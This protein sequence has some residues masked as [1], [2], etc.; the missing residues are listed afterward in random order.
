MKAKQGRVTYGS[1]AFHQDATEAMGGDIIRALIETVTNSDDAYG[2][3]TGKIR[4][5]VDHRRGPWTVVTR[6]RATGMSASRMEEA[7]AHLG[8]RTSGFEDGADVRGNLGRGSK[9]LAA[10]G[11][12]DFE[13]LCEDEYAH[14]SLDPDG[15][16]SLDS[17]RRALPRERDRLGIP[18]GNGTVVTIHATDSIRCP[19][20]QKL[21]EKLSRHYQLRDI[22]SDPI[23]EVILVDKNKEN[24][25]VLRF[26]FPALPVVDSTELSIQDYP[27]A[28]TKLTILRNT[29]RYDDPQSDATRPAGILI[30]GRRAIYENSLFRFESN[31]YAGWFSGRI[32]CPFIDTL[33]AEYDRKLLAHEP[34]DPRNPVPIITRRRDG[35]Q[36]G[37]PFYKA[38]AAAVEKHIG[39]L[40]AHEEKNA[41]EQTSTESTHLRKM[42][43]GLG[44]D[45]SKLI[46]EDLREID[47][48]GLLGSQSGEAL[49]PIKVIPEE[50][51]LY[52]G[53]EKTVS[54]MVLP[55]LCGEQIH[56]QCEP[57]G[58]VELLD[59]SA[60]GLAP[61]KKRPDL[62][63][64]QVHLRPL[65]EDQTLLT[66]TC[67]EH[68]AVALVEV[69]PERETIELPLVPAD[70]FQFERDN[71]RVAWTRKK[72]LRI[73]AP[74]ADV[75]QYGSDV[76]ISSSDPGVVVRTGKI[77]LVLDEELEQYSAQ[78]TIEAR[79]LSAKAK[80]TANLGPLATSC[81][82]VVS[83][84]EE[85]PSLI[86][87]IADEEAGNYRAI[88]SREG[89]QTTIKVMGRHPIMK[90]YR[91]PATEFPGDDSPATQLVVA[92]IVADQVARMILEKKFPSSVAEHIDAARFYVEH[93]KYMS[94]YL[95]RCHKA[96]LGED[97]LAQLVAVHETVVSQLP[98]P[99]PP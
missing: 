21:A 35:L 50:V 43:D 4:I 31:P 17:P 48:D 90:R 78:S 95:Q 54:V 55:G 40:V 22:M 84:E 12:V 18:R 86:I 59:G 45:L 82:V 44:R 92:E 25:D 70:R 42:L 27:E 15:N 1:R 79:A 61:H 63:A 71:Y 80:L 51:V 87:K 26:A 46:D 72:Q 30:K 20:H 7:I 88:V 41:Q 36:H 53:E 69:R 67:G 24:S 81:R 56:V 13:S 60:V 2:P 39:P 49:P 91:G 47:E 11:K 99:N 19:Q 33:A 8:A 38:L 32:E 29:E 52:M 93:Y 9:D 73:L 83:K 65:L 68:S 75:A 98:L 97:Q 89:A 10:F 77:T 96:L 76:S 64:G 14:M 62:L 85:G 37:H 57:A 3:R 5:E 34:A 94:K 74:L 6:D 28:Q 66:A 58:V 16:Y 23:R